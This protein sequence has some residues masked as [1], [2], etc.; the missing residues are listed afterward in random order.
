VLKELVEAYL[1]FIVAGGGAGTNPVRGKFGR[2]IAGEASRAAAR[3]FTHYMD[4]IYRCLTTQ[5]PKNFP[6]TK[7]TIMADIDWMKAQ[8]G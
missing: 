5:F 7:K 4:D 3:R 1:G 2:L 8:M 6:A